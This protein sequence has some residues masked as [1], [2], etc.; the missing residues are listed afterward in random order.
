MTSIRVARRDDY[1]GVC[2]VTRELDVF[3]ADALPRFFRPFE[4][5][6]RSQQWF[7]EALENPDVLLLV[8]E[9]DGMMVGLLT[10]LVRQNPDLPMFVP[11]RWLAVDNVAVLSAYRRLGIGRALMEQAHAWAQAQ[12]L[13]EVEL[14][15]WE[16]NQEA[17]AF[18]ETLGY[19]TILRRLWK[20]IE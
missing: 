6:V 17:L 7:S 20:G 16:F 11:R 19:T 5:P 1:E 15:V 13:T 2:A 12:R 3:H 14:T 10:G 9:H 8:A 18:Y 4:G